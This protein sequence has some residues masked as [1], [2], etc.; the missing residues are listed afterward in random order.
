[1]KISR[2]FS[3]VLIND[4]VLNHVK[5]PWIIDRK[6]VIDINNKDENIYCG[7]KNNSLL[8]LF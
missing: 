5:K 7:H 4:F 1:M 6:E 8:F 2:S 3:S